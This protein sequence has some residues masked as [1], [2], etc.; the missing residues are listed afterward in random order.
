MRARDIRDIKQ[1][2]F[3]TYNIVPNLGEGPNTYDK[4]FLT[5]IPVKPE[6]YDRTRYHGLNLCCFFQK[7][8]IEFRHMSGTFQFDKVVRSF[9]MLKHL[10]T[11]AREMPT[12]YF[13]KEG[14]ILPEKYFEMP[15]MEILAHVKRN[16]RQYISDVFTKLQLPTA[17]RKF[18][19]ARVRGFNSQ[20]CGS[21]ALLKESDIVWQTL[22]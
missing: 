17:T 21:P 7:N 8:T 4:N 19:L 1:I 6:R 11:M 16:M 10:L 2:W 22:A 15:Y 18:L 14:L 12:S 13:L 5:N 3:A 20:S 9:N